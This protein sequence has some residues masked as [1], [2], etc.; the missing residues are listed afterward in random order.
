MTIP[1]TL[2]TMT[3]SYSDYCNNPSYL[4]PSVPSSIAQQPSGGSE[5]V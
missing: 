4:V 3:T 5:N 2:V 1:I